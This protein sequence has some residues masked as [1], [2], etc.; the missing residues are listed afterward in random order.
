MICTLLDAERRTIADDTNLVDFPPP[1]TNGQKEWEQRLV[2]QLLPYLPKDQVEAREV[3]AVMKEAVE[4]RSSSQ[5]TWERAR[6]AAYLLSMFAEDYRAA[7][8]IMNQFSCEADVQKCVT[9]VA[10]VVL[11]FPP[12]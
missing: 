11:G 6:Q 5:R 3:I 1:V 9:V 4:R 2:K 8:R 12:A 10:A 7:R